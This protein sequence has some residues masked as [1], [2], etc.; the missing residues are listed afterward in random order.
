MKYKLT[1]KEL[2]RYILKKVKDEKNYSL[3]E[4]KLSN[5]KFLMSE[6]LKTNKDFIEDINEVVKNIFS[7]YINEN[8]MI[9]VYKILKE[10]F[11]EKIANELIK[12]NLK[13]K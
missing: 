10:N 7:T 3:L 4:K 2:T 8:K 11:N 5:G 6:G 9:K 13:S 12:I 1:E